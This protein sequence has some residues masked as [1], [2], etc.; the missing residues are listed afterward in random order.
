[1]TNLIKVVTNYKTSKIF[2]D[3]YKHDSK[4]IPHKE[5]RNIIK[6]FLNEINNSNNVIL[7]IDQNDNINSG[8]I[9]K[10]THEKGIHVIM[11]YYNEKSNSY[12]IQ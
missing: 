4:G 12:V 9:S 2:C 10:Y 11:F 7:F 6:P 1:M 3:I 8:Q 5:F